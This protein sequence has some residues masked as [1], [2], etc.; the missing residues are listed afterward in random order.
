MSEI[1]KVEVEVTK[2][3]YELGQCLVNLVKAV[4]A[5]GADGWQVGTDVPAVVMAAM[6]ALPAGVNGIQK[7]S[8]EAHEGAA[9]V[10]AFG[11]AAKDLAG[12]FLKK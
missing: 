11:L 5:A 6:A 7:L 10:A 1:L 12:V 8:E 4:K 3:A 2:E 9:F